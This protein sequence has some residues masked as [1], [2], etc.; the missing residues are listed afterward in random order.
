MLKKI[1]V[2]GTTSNGEQ[3]LYNGVL[4][5]PVLYSANSQKSLDVNNALT[6]TLPDVRGYFN[7]DSPV[8]EIDFKELHKLIKSQFPNFKYNKVYR[9][10]PNTIKYYLSGSS[11]TD[12]IRQFIVNELGYQNISVTTR[13]GN[14]YIGKR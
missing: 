6:M 4:P 14:I 13:D 9:N 3:Y 12:K 11:M 1:A 8:Q 2:K 10:G 7:T 5:T